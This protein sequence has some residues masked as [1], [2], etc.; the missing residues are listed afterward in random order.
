MSKNS[1]KIHKVFFSII[2]LFLIG[3]ATFNSR[4]L[5]KGP[6]VTVSGLEDS[7]KNTL[8]AKT[9]DFSLQGIASHSSFISINN[10]PILVDEQGNFNEKLLLSN[11]V[12]IID[13]Y[14]RDKFGKEVRKKIDIVYASD[15]PSLVAEYNDIALRAQIASTSKVLDEVILSD[16]TSVPSLEGNLNEATSSAT[17]TSGL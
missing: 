14:A 11:G 10:R 15:S 17:S 2:V 4:F 3:Y 9:K 8:Y 5:I 16:E 13:I 6:E 1:Q 12:S 7:T